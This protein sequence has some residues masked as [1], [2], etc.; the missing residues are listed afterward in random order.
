MLSSRRMSTPKPEPVHY[1]AGETVQMTP[2][3]HVFRSFRNDFVAAIYSRYN[4]TLVHVQAIKTTA[5]DAV[6]YA[7]RYIK[8]NQNN[9]FGDNPVFH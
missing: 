4:G 6:R 7:R 8:N 3:M 2:E 1:N 5:E 9:V